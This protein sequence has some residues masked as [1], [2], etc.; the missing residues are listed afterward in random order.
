MPASVRHPGIWLLTGGK[1][2][3]SHRLKQWCRRHAIRQRFGAVGQRGSIA[4]VERFMR[5]LKEGTRALTRVSLRRRSFHLDVQRAIGWYNADR[6]HMTLTGATP[7]EIYHAR[8]AAC[9]SPRFEPRPGWPRVARCARPQVLVKGQPGV[10]LQL[11]VELLANQRHLPR[12]TIR[13]AA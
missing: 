3:C 9:R 11:Q 1:Q 13:R 5:T 8:R 2:F 12:V 7:D 10:R 4:V 6:P